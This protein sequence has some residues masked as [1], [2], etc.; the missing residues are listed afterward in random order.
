MSVQ[1]G[2]RVKHRI[3]G[4]SGIITGTIEYI[5]GCRQHLVIPEELDKDGKAQEG[6]WVDEQHLGL[7]TKAVY[8]N[9]FAKGK[10]ATAGGPDRRSLPTS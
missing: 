9:P 10:K 4:A 8:E 5:N 7:V 1:L 3:N 2:D 6:W